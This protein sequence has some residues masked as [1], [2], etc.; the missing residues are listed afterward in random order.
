MIC[1]WT[2]FYG[3]KRNTTFIKTPSD[4]EELCNRIITNLRQIR[5]RDAVRTVINLL[6]VVNLCLEVEDTNFPIEI[7]NY[8]LTFYTIG[9]ES[10]ADTFVK[11][12]QNFYLKCDKVSANLVFPHFNNADQNSVAN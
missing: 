8:P 1:Y 6:K 2:I 5:R 10:S 4:V 3:E 7:K 9:L 11:P 12:F